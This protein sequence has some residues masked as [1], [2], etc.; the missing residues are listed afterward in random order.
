MNTFSQ[1]C[2]HYSISI[3]QLKIFEIWKKYMHCWL[4]IPNAHWKWVNLTLEIWKL[5]NLTASTTREQKVALSFPKCSWAMPQ[6][7]AEWRQIN[8][9]LIRFATLSVSSALPKSLLSWWHRRRT[10]SRRQY[11]PRRAEWRGTKQPQND[12]LNISWL[13]TIQERKAA[14]F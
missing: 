9:F 14:F 10:C 6:K 5:L 13:P 7:P 1:R 12:S 11:A 2:I 3:I 8:C 4:R